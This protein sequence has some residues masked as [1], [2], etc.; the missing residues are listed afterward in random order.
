MNMV[1]ESSLELRL[2]K[3][4]ETRNYLDEIKHNNLMIQKYKKTIKYLNYVEHIFT[5]ASTVIGCFSISAFASLVCVFEGIT[6]S[7]I[8]IKIYA[9]TAGIKRF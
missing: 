3:C 4:D 2:R 7:A 5:L 8:R 1:E 6:S 9:I